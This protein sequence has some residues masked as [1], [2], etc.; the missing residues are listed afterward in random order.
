MKYRQLGSTGYEVSEIGFGAWA[1]GADW[2]SVDDTTAMAAL[3]AAVDAG[4]TLID[5]ADVYGDGRSERFVAQ[6]VKERSDVDLV[7]ATKAGR[8]LDPHV[9]DG[10]TGANIEAF[11]DRSLVNLDAESLDLLQLHC[12]PT[13]VYYRPEM[14][15]AL[16]EIKAKGKIKHYGVSVERVEE[17]M[18]AIEYPGVE[19]VQIIFNMFRQRPAERFLDLAVAG[20]I[21]VI[22]R[23]PLASGLLTGKMRA[24][25]EFAA[26]DHRNYNRHGEAFDVGETF[27][28]VDYA[29]GL[30]AVD[31][32]E[33]LRPADATMAQFALRWILMHDGVSTAIPGAKNP[34]QAVA[35]AAASDLDALDGATM[36]AVEGVYDRSIRS[37]VHARW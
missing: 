17:A 1:I 26:S 9:A 5:T 30:A 21:G 20:D 7:V 13:D 8:R 10:Y 28:G 19:T 29:T 12:P 32:I 18:K 4:V 24:D 31:E 36:A 2:G 3:N 6:L 25:T 11:I 23:V 35:N 37:Q 34:T 15:A 14:F 33:A 16:D 22:V 27:A